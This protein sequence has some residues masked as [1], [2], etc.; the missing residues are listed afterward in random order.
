MSR[1]RRGKNI[2]VTTRHRR[3]RRGVVVQSRPEMNAGESPGHGTHDNK[4][5]QHLSLGRAS[6]SRRRDFQFVSA[7]YTDNETTRLTGPIRQS[8]GGSSPAVGDLRDSNGTQRMV[9]TLSGL[10]ASPMEQRESAQD[11]HIWS[12][13]TQCWRAETGLS[14]KQST[15]VAT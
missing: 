7:P 6:R 3:D 13:A 10:T 12:K 14:H 2:S 1:Q 11:F 5:R 15:N 9:K 4:R 8:T